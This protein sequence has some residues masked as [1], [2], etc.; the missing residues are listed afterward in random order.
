VLRNIGPRTASG[1]WGLTGSLVDIVQLGECAN[2]FRSC[3]CD[4]SLLP[5]RIVEAID[6]GLIS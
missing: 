1:L 2:H 3:G 6:R 4:P 5:D